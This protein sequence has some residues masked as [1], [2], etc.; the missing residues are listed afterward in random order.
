MMGS[1]KKLIRIN[2]EMANALTPALSHPMREGERSTRIEFA[3]FRF[4]S[5]VKKSSPSPV[6][7]VRAGVRVFLT[8]SNISKLSC[9]ELDASPLLSIQKFY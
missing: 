9:G 5:H 1:A 3:L 6:V 2:V 4:W 8:I 7:G